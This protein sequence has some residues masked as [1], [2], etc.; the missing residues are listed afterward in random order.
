M[1][2]GRLVSI[3]LLLQAEG[4]LTSKQLAERL[5]VTERTILRDMDELSAS[6]IPVYSER[7]AQ[8]GWQLTE[9]YRTGLTGLHADELAALLVSSQDHP[10][11]ELGR[12]EALDAALMKLLAG[13]N[14]SARESA[15][16]VRRKLHIDGASWH[17][18]GAGRAGDGREQPPLLPILQEAV[19]EERAVRMC[20]DSD[21]EGGRAARIIRPLGLVVKR[22]VW[23]VVALNEE[24][25]P[26]TFRIS[27]M[28]DAEALP[29][30][31]EPPGDFELAAYWE[32]SL[33]DFK[34]R[35]PRY[36]ARVR[37]QTALLRRLEGERYVSS[38]SVAAQS[39]R[40]GWAE[41]EV[42]FETMESA[43]GILLRYGSG[44]E[45]LGPPELRGLIE[46]EIEA[47]RVLYWKGAE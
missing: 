34:K 12:Q 41:A 32:S 18:S 40:E 6:G 37:V 33:S 2:A 27:R 24:G 26:R 46:D 9:G 10:L 17:S 16:A 38:V 23:Y 44:I 1:R 36:P 19:W 21:K 42:L 4:R 14:E 11:R 45:A 28:L 39:E 3:V 31:F 25:E 29:A 15:K 30:R 20:Y 8:G 5:E 43:C 22:N 7:G 13:A 35:L 47:M